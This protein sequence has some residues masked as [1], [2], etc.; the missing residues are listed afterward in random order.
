MIKVGIIGCGT[1]AGNGNLSRSL[2]HG[3]VYSDIRPF[4]IECCF[5]LNKK[6]SKKFAKRYN[7][8]ISNNILDTIDIYDCDVISICT[9]D[10][11]HFDITKK[12]LSNKILPKLIFLEKPAATNKKNIQVLKKLS[13]L[14]KVPIVINM[15]NRFN[16]NIIKIKNDIMKKKYGKLLQIQSLYYGGII[17][18]GIHVLDTLQFLFNQKLNLKEIYEFSLYNKKKYRDYN[19]NCKLNFKS[20]KSKVYIN[21]FNEDN[22]QIYDTLCLSK[23]L[24]CV[25]V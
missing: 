10:L 20:I 24:S 14:K 15:S 23:L 1:I 7:C 21:Y 19:V 9:D 6:K 25:S 22:Y 8:K 4:K 13:K 17:H 5:D 16:Q 2:T 12:I 11:S 18:N 3:G